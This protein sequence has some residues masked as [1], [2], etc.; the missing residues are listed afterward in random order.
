MKKFLRLSWG[1]DSTPLNLLGAVVLS[2]FIMLYINTFIGGFGGIP[3]FIAYAFCFFLIRSV[4]KAGNR[5]SH[6]V[7]ID[8]ARELR[9][10]YF[11]Y[12][13]GYILFYLIMKIVQVFAGIAGWGNIEGKSFGEYL[14][15]LYGTTIMER[16]AYIF[17]LIFT[18]S[19]VLSL[20]PLVIIRKTSTWLTYA[21]CDLVFHTIAVAILVIAAAQYIRRADMKKVSCLLDALLLCQ[22]KSTGKVVLYLILIGIYV[23]VAVFGSY[24]IARCIYRPKPGRVI[25]HPEKYVTM[26]ETEIEQARERSRKKIIGI[27]AGTFLVVAAAAFLFVYIFFIQK[28]EEDR[29]K[30]VGECLTG[31]LCRG[32]IAYGSTV[33]VPVD[34]DCDLAESGVALGYLAK[35]GENTASR[36]YRLVSAN[37][38][39]KSIN[40][41]Q[42]YLQVVGT[43]NHTYLPMTYIEKQE[44]WRKD[45][46]FLLWDED[47]KG[48]SLY[49]K[50]VTGYSVC[51]K[52][53]IT[54]LE[55]QFGY[56]NYA[57]DDFKD[58]DAYFTISG[59]NDI[60][61][62]FMNDGSAGD[63]VGCILVKDD[64]FYYGSYENEI[65]GELL[66]LL[67]SVLGGA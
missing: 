54:K 10:I 29:F 64:R 61:Q 42:L 33:Y 67:H 56:V 48:E 49:S 24:S 65:T 3:A 58:Y 2:F 5:I 16:W 32:P 50:E 11:S 36:Y 62:A 17:V 37:V 38:L 20:F 40:K 55:E 41:S 57:T 23:I 63:W 1:A 53:L 21:F 35:Q 4:Q 28:D 15:G 26:T 39:Y 45:E 19:F 43:E 59:Y 51:P 12:A 52:E 6:F 25:E 31:D 44:F 9:Y 66:E 13:E 18:I 27:S 46:L 8:S 14:N 30:Q 47:W 7:A 60:Q 34:A 22:I